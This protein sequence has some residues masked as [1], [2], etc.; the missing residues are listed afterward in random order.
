M[1]YRWLDFVKVIPRS[2]LISVFLGGGV[3]A[4]I[5]RSDFTASLVKVKLGLWPAICGPIDIL[6][7]VVN[8]LHLRP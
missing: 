8:G 7:C 5:G 6:C 4:V 3:G 2:A 1:M